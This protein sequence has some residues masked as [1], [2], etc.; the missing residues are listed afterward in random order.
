MT[1]ILALD[2]LRRTEQRLRERSDMSYV[3]GQLMVSVEEREC[4]DQISEAIRMLTE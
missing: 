4:A 3:D 1:E 2:L